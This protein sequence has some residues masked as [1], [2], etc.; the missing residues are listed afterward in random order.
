MRVKN[1][2][3]SGVVTK[4]EEEAKIKTRRKKSDYDIVNGIPIR[5]NRLDTIITV[6]IKGVV[7]EIKGDNPDNI[8]IGENIYDR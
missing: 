7:T 2:N 5:K 8:K 3:S 1:R 6:D 4:L